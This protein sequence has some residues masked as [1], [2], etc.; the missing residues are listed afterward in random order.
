MYQPAMFREV[1][2]AVLH[3]LIR[4]FPFATMVVIHSAGVEISH[5]PLVLDATKQ[6]LIGNVAKANP[7]AK[8]LSL[9]SAA[10]TVVFNGEHGYISPSYYLQPEQNVPTWN[11]AVVHVYGEI[12]LITD[13]ARLMDILDHL[14]SQ[15]DATTTDWSNPKMSAQ[16]KGISGFEINICE[17]NGKF[18]LSQNKETDEQKH[19]VQQLAKSNST[20]DVKLAE[21]MQDYLSIKS[22]SK[23]NIV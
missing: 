1:N 15:Y 11:Y 18:K 21:F 16:L 14:Q 5:V 10:V 19:L 17:V 9:A 2:Q 23:E 13:E 20:S 12:S 6:K 4:D 22:S 7:L 8:I 3:E